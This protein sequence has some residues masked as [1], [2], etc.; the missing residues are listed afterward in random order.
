MTD[1]NR[2]GRTALAVLVTAVVSVGLL[3]LPA[4]ASAARDG[5]RAALGPVVR[6]TEPIQGPVEGFVE[7]QGDRLTLDGRP[8][9]FAGTNN[10]Y[11][12]YGADGRGNQVNVTNVLDNAQAAGFDAMRM[13]AFFD[14][15]DPDEPGRTS[16]IHGAG[17]SPTWFQAWDED[18]EAPM[19]NEGP[20]GLSQLDYA[21][22]EAGERG[23][24]AVLPFTGNWSSFGGMD[25]YVRWRD[26]ADDS[27]RVWYHDDFYTD[28][29]IKGWYKD[30][31]TYLLNRENVY[32]GVAYKDDPTVLMWELG[33][34]PRCRGS[35]LPSSPGACDEGMTGDITAWAD[36]MS[37][38]I[39]SI[40]ANHLVGVGDEG[41]FCD[42]STDDIGEGWACTNG[43]DGEAL[44]ALPTIDVVGMHLY[45]DHWGYD[46]A[47]GDEWIAAHGELGKRVGKPVVLGEFGIEPNPDAGVHRNVVYQSWLDT[48]YRS[49]VDGTLYWIL[50]SDLADGTPYPDYDGFTVYCPSAICTT[51]SNNAQRVRTNRPVF[52]PIADVDFVQTDYGAPTTVNVLA[53]DISYLVRLVP[54]TIDLDPTASGRQTTVAVDGGRFTI[55]RAGVVDFVPADGFA[56][57][58]R[59][60]YTVADRSGRLSDLA[61]ITIR[62]RPAPDA[63]ITLFSF[64]DGTQGWGSAGM[65]TATTDTWS[66]DGTRSL[67]VTLPEGTSGWVG[68]PFP[69][70]VDASRRQSLSLDVRV[71]GTG[72]S[73]AVSLQVGPDFRWCQST[74]QYFPAGTSTTRTIDLATDMSCPVE[75]LADIRKMNVFLNSGTH[76][77]D[78]VVLR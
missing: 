16:S 41:W 2:R 69:A 72:S 58:A 10:Y 29:V 65:T 12:M 61:E 60:S 75:D 8:Y 23:I 17:N 53:N 20:F 67:Q 37:R 46:A 27:D 36:E 71:G 25:Q 39:K 4:T 9:V 63:P 30:W 55:G 50:S 70:P 45:P 54:G 3:G 42:P 38:H 52:P 51:I 44:A 11:L 6:A 49:G 7:A 48:A 31:I 32:T 26:L 14:V 47:W 62:V 19:Y 56:G 18:S 66:T 59:A 1:R 78:Q 5:T 35:A 21:V 64:E 33:N 40:D 43:V 76:L 28:P 57:F 74:F 77:I 15:Q 68:G 13:W 34:E 22:A 24:R 73:V